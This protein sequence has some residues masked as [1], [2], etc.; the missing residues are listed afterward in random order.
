[1]N[2]LALIALSI[3][4]YY[5]ISKK[6][7]TGTGTSTAPQPDTN[8]QRYAIAEYMDGGGDSAEFKERFSYIVY[9]RLSPTEVNAMYIYLFNYEQKGIQVPVGS[10]LYN[11]IRTISE[12]YNI[13]T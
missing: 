5:F 10:Q 3:G 11:Q 7:N 13:F 4:A 6:K 12:K 8:Y 2:P 9:N 1:M